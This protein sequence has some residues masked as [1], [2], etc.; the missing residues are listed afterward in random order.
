MEKQLNG[1]DLFAGIGGFSLG[2]RGAFERVGIDYRTLCYVENDQS[3]QQILKSRM[4]D[5]VHTF[6]NI[7]GDIREFNGEEW[8]GRID[9]IT[10]GFPCQDISLA[11]NRAGIKGKR[12]GLFFEMWRVVCEVRPAIVIM[13]NV[14][15][16]TS[17]GYDLIT[18]E[19][20]ASGYSMQWNNLSAAAVGSPHQR[21]RWFAVAYADNTGK[22]QEKYSDRRKAEKI[23]KWAQNTRPQSCG[24]SGASISNSMLKRCDCRRTNCQRC[25]KERQQSDQRTTLS[26]TNGTRREKFNTSTKSETKGFD[27]GISDKAGSFWSAEPLVGRVVDGFSGRNDRIRALGNAV[28]PQVVAEVVKRMLIDDKEI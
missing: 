9:I 21:D 13:E 15:A 4:Y 19:V 6:G 16:I 25:G 2:V 22:P 5:G 10:G 27:S 26:H 1:I 24:H 7:Y 11:G 17:T 8:R 3:C 28:V 12:S 14:P 20:A 23:Q 18:K